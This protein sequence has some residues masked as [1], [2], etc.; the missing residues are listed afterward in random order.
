MSRSAAR[1]IPIEPPTTIDRPPS[2]IG[3]RSSPRIRSA[4]AIASSSLRTPPRSTA[5]SSPLW[6]PTTSSARTA[7]TS[8]SR[9]LDE[10]LVAGR[11][12]VRVVD[13]LEVVEV[14]EEEARPSRGSGPAGP[15]PARGDRGAG[16]GS[17]GPVS[18]SCSASWMSFDSSRFRSV[19]SISRPCD[20]CRP[21]CGVVGHRVGL[22]ADPDLGAVAGE[23]PVLGAEGLAGPPVLA[24]TP[25]S[26]PRGPRGGSG[27]ARAPGSFDELL[28]PIAEDAGDLRAHVGEAT[29]VGDVGIGQ[30]DVDG[31]RDVLD[32]DLQARAGLLDLA[33]GRARVFGGRRAG[34]RRGRPRPR[35]PRTGRPARRRRR[36]VPPRPIRRR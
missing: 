2:W 30:V 6:R 17:P 12:A 33:G 13:P 3:R 9:D 10:D 22:V 25:R 29:A 8:R 18:G 27:S 15:A 14:D 24:R 34:A 20:I 7:P 1:A 11:V 28:G 16:P 31:G 26:R 35:G 5:N 32:E 23:H 36:R 4:D 21:L 19:M